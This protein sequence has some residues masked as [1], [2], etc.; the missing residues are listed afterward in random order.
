MNNVCVYCQQILLQNEKGICHNC[1]QKLLDRDVN[2]LERY[3]EKD[4][5]EL[6]YISI[7]IDDYFQ[8][9]EELSNFDDLLFHKRRVACINDCVGYIDKK[10]FLPRTA[11]E[12]D[13]FREE[14]E[15]FCI[16][17]LTEKQKSLQVKN[18]IRDNYYGNPRL[19]EYNAKVTLASLM[20]S[21]EKLDWSWWQY[22]EI[23]FFDLYKYVNKN[24][25]I[26]I[27]EKYFSNEI[28]CFFDLTDYYKE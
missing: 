28:K 16:G 24:Q 15:K 10:L 5:E 27:A 21:K 3:R 9:N 18:L 20:S 2:E 23:V 7:K 26:E 11:Q 12:V 8:L 6:F 14:V 1:K 25:L 19:V 13:Y 22:M 17:K 4:I